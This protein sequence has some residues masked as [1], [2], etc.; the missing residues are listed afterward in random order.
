MTN[1]ND[2]A[3]VT[4]Y[5]NESQLSERFR[6]ELRQIGIP[7]RPSILVEI[8]REYQKEE[9]D[10]LRLADL[11]GS[12]VGI[13]AGLI[14]VAN[15]SFFALPKTVRSVR[16]TL[17]VLGMHQIVEIV[18][19]LALDKI[20]ANSP[21]MERFWDGS[22]RTA[23]VSAWLANRFRNRWAIR[24]E[25]AY[26]FGLFRDCGIPLILVPFPEY[27]SVLAQANGTTDGCFTDVEDR[28][29]DVNHAV[30][31]AEM[32]QTWRLPDEFTL[33][34]RHHHQLSWAMESNTLQIPRVSWM[35]IAIA[36]LA[37]YLIQAKTGRSTS[38]EWDKA[39]TTVVQILNLSASD[40]EVLDAASDGVVLD[41]RLG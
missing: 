20:F 25:D 15:S 39:A 4:V 35:L 23:R 9:T 37:E 29:L 36:Q 21:T 26:T 10:F 32:S 11:I 3:T 38:H 14:K 2:S 27:K 13:S 22:S 5:G 7:P 28:L 6:L 18:T 24:P 41:R 31:G 30:I 40:L 33:A 8:E 16:E 34:V 19:T 1:K 17:L 12:D